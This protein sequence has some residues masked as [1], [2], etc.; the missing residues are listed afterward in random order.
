MKK[1]KNPFE[2]LEKPFKEILKIVPGILKIIPLTIKALIF[3]VVS[4]PKMIFNLIK[5]IYK[6]IGKAAPNTFAIIVLF[7]LIF[8]GF[9]ILMRNLLGPGI[10]TPPIILGIF[11]LF[12]IYSLV[13]N[14]SKEISL[15]QKI[16]LDLFLK[17]FNNDITRD[18]FK[19]NIPV[20][21]KHPEKSFPAILKWVS[22][23]L[24]KVILTL[25]IIALF[26]KMFIIKLWEY[27]T[28]L[29]GR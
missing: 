12:I 5:S 8:F 13:I 16:L 1:I 29:S 19:F 3:L 11:T 28:V 4:L 6:F 15:F 25:I 2:A 9:Q 27:F 24:I 14:E 23:N 21:K 20:D 22:K 7:M 26:V 10:I 18:L 17:I